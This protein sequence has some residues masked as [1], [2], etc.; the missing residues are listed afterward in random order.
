MT[1]KTE[2]RHL[3]EALWISPGTK[4]EQVRALTTLMHSP[5]DLTGLERSFQRQIDTQEQIGPQM[6]SEAVS[7]Q[8]YQDKLK[9]FYGTAKTKEFLRLAA[10]DLKKLLKDN[11]GLTASIVEVKQLLTKAWENQ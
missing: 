9:G 5:E 10:P 8:L 2:V 7:G 6:A 11:H 1:T 3:I 4:K